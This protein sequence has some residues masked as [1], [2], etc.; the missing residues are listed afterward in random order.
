METVDR[1]REAAVYRR[2][3]TVESAA[4]EGA[5][6]LQI[7]TASQTQNTPQRRIPLL[8]TVSVGIDGRAQSRYI[9]F[10]AIIIFKKLL[11]NTFL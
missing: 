7:P 2:S 10:P 1:G 5:S 9:S 11:K 3:Q 8:A 4:H 6:R